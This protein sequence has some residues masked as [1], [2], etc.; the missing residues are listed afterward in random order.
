M[1]IINILTRWEAVQACTLAVAGFAKSWPRLCL[2]GLLLEAK[3]PRSLLLCSECEA[4][5]PLAIIHPRGSKQMDSDIYGRIFEA[6]DRS[7]LD[8]VLSP[9]IALI[10]SQIQP[11][12]K[13]FMHSTT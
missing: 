11:R 3:H 2:L 7:H 9:L 10:D 8:C 5:K 1:T 12:T 6:V 4:S 13:C